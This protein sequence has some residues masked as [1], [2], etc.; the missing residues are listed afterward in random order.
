MRS[1][2]LVLTIAAFAAVAI[3]DVNVAGK[4]SGSFKMTSPEGQSGD[5]TAFLTLTQSG[6]NIAGTV[7]PNESE[8]H[9]I[10]KGKIEGDKITLVIE[11]DGRTIQFDLVVTA[12]R[13]T[14]NV[15]IAHDGESRKGTIDVTR[16][17]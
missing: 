3:A 7:G 6:S 4:W 1:M 11:E 17:K 15:N 10:T 9:T 8:Q 14:G 13:I 16:A 12:D 2:V 5:S